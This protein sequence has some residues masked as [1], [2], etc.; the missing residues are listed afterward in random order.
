MDPKKSNE[1]QERH[2]LQAFMNLD[3]TGA[4][5]VFKLTC[6]ASR[7]ENKQSDLGSKRVTSQ[8]RLDFHSML[9]IHFSWLF[10]EDHIERG[11]FSNLFL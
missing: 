2:A 8:I 5:E 11:L 4:Q 9:P 10:F 3:K 6:V 7:E 1:K